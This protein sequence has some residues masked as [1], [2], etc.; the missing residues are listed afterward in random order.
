[1]NSHICLRALLFAAMLTAFA[2]AEAQPGEHRVYS[3]VEYNEE[4]GDLVGTELDLTIGDGRVDGTLRI[5]QGG[6]ADPIRFAGSASQGKLQVSGQSN[7]F[8]KVD[9]VGTLLR[10]RFSGSIR[11]EKARRPEKI[12]LTKIAKPHC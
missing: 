8:G 7:T 6:C 3:N 12:R 10:D 11:L 5:Y 9:I 2:S 4:G 1:M